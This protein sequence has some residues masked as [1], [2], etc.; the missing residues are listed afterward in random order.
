MLCDFLVQ[1]APLDAGGKLQRRIQRIK[2]EE[3][4][5]RSRRWT[6]T[7]VFRGAKIRG[8]LH[9]AGRSSAFGNVSRLRIDVPNQPM[10]PG[11]ARGIRIINDQRA[12]LVP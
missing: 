6:G 1:P 2:P 3:I 9:A 8:A 10:I 12:D 7:A 5:V 4:P 11:A